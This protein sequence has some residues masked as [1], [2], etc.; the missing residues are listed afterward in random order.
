MTTATAKTTAK[1]TDTL[2]AAFLKAQSEFPDIGKDSEAGAGSFTYK[3]ASLPAILRECLPVLHE[4]GFALSQTF[5]GGAMTTRLIH[6]AGEM[7]SEIPCDP[8]GLKPQDFGALVS[9]MRRYGFIAIVGIA[10][11]ED[12]DAADVETPPP[13]QP[14]VTPQPTPQ[15]EDDKYLSAVG[16][17]VERGR[18][19]FSVISE[20]GDPV[21]EMKERVKTVLSH[22]GNGLAVAPLSIK[23][24]PARVKF[25]KDLEDMVKAIEEQANGA[26][27]SGF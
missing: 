26:A 25:F 6:E 2:A 23:G 16:D 15:H 20:D 5:G 8:A 7:K 10:P 12:T 13:V 18:T 14:S 17:L 3:Y 24:K 1:K 21:A 4:N 11:D 9:Y 22:Q 27:E 19:A